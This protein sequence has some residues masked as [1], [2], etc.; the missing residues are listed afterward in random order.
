MTAV[1]DSLLD[2]FFSLFAK[3]IMAI[4]DVFIFLGD[5]LFFQLPLLL[6]G[7]FL[8]VVFTK[9]RSPFYWKKFDKQPFKTLKACL[10][11]QLFKKIALNYIRVFTWYFLLFVVLMMLVIFIPEEGMSVREKF[12]DQ[13]LALAL[14]CLS[15]FT[16]VL[17][18]FKAACYAM[19]GAIQSVGEFKL[20][21]IIL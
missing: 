10:N 9:A 4:A 15:F 8:A 19:I 13:N 17:A 11:H 1:L 3:G 12:T 20:K 16:I 7:I 5:F 6:L 18:F 21:M 2:L 14:C